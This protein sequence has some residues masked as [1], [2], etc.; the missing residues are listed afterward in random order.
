MQQLVIKLS[1]FF[2]FIKLQQ[3]HFI[4]FVVLFNFFL[5]LNF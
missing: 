2:Q 4:A 5:F 3:V 1:N